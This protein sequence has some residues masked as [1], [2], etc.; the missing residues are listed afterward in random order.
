MFAMLRKPASSAGMLW[1][2]ILAVGCASVGPDFQKPEVDTAE[3][4]LQAEDERVDTA[5]TE[6][7]DWWTVFEDPALNQL[8][9]RAYGENLNLQVAGLRVLEARAHLGFATGLRYPQSQ[10]VGASYVR[11]KSSENA[12]PFSNLPDDV[13][14][15]IDT[16]INLWSTS[17]DIAWEADVWG[18]FR[19]GIEAADANLAANMLN[20]DAV[21]VTLTGD[22]ALV[23]ATIR[24]LEQRLT[25][26]RE[27][28][29]L[30]EQG[31]E[32]AETRFELG[33]ASELD[34]Q[35]S[36][37]LLESTRAL[38][39]LL[40]AQISRAK[41]TLSLLLGMPPND[42]QDI[43]GGASAIP[44]A[45]TQAAVGIPADLIRRRPDV[46]A[47]E[48]AAAAQSAAIGVAT[49][50]LYPQFVL[51]GSFGLTGESFSDQFESGSGSGFLSPLVNW[52]IFNYGRIKNNV[53]V[54]DARFQ[55]LVTIYENVVLNAAREV[56]DGL[57]GFLRA[58]EEVQHLEEAVVALQRSVELS[59]D[60][61]ESGLVD[62]QRVLNSQASLLGQ[63][64][65]LAD[66]RGRILSSLVSTYRALG[67]G[68]Q[69]RGANGY[70]DPD[71]LNEMR[72]RTNWGDLLD[73]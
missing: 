72:E 63:Q 46:R 48:M 52:N 24:T 42:L 68:W 8:I 36:R 11:S 18:R 40:E 71:T 59:L 67:G 47:A 30:Q 33:A 38:I 16:S 37:G 51:A 9:E 35:Q 64:D 43:L 55:Q 69:L 20:Y 3:A 23:Y 49:A 62:F 4:W 13:V 28:T 56:E 65:S 7:E 44:G 21:L 34:V 1:F 41:N 12:P 29:T 26:V 19:R 17:F 66:A 39:P 61:Y 58:Q 31:L 27:N 32:L 14:D 2:A 45:P 57:V 60:Q 50:D 53:R 10:S 15:R 22:V 5:R 70:V 54:Q 73:N 6:Y 25:Y